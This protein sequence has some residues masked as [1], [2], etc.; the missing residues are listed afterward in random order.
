MKKISAIIIP[1]LLLLPVLLSAKDV[2]PVDEYTNTITADWSWRKAK[3][4]LI[5]GAGDSLR[6]I[7]PY[8]GRS[9]KGKAYADVVNRYKQVLGEGVNVYCMLVPTSTE[10]YCPD[11]ARYLTRSEAAYFN[12]LHGFLADSVRVVDCYSVLSHHVEEPI[13]S[14]TDHH[15][16]P[17]GAFYAARELAKAAGVPFYDLEEYEVVS[18]PGYVGSMYSFSGSREVL[19]SPE[20]FVY[21]VPHFVEYTTTYTVYNMDKGNKYVVSKNAPQKGQFFFKFKS[22]SRAMYCTFMG[23]DTKLTK[24]ETSVPGGRKL[25]ILKDSFGN[26]VPGYLLGSFSE[27][28]VVDCRY[29]PDNIAKYIK[30]NGITDVAFVNNTVHAS[31]SAVISNYNKYLDR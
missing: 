23:G 27:V 17:L 29:Y 4:V 22:G 30:A 10:F 20:D 31:S 15:W 8:G 24:V 6:V 1:A 28:H 25:L 21:F 3:N 16:A 12:S 19:N 5:V 13:Y 7:A 2:P 9:D 11:S 18:I 26:A 14:R